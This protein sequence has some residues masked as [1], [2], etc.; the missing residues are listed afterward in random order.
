MA[1]FK[2]VADAKAFRTSNKKPRQS[3]VVKNQPLKKPIV[4]KKSKAMVE[5]QKQQKM[6]NLVVPK[7]AFALLVRAITRKRHAEFRFQNLALE[8]LQQA[9]EAI[10]IRI[11]SDCVMLAEHAKRVTIM[12]RDMRLLIMILRPSWNFQ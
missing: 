9:T 6:T 11:L 2:F 5:V 12:D 1:I 3:I 7:S 8:C 4:L 10:L